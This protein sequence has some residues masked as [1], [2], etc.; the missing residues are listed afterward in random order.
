MWRWIKI[1]APRELAGKAGAGVGVG[2]GCWGGINAIIASR[3]DHQSINEVLEIRDPQ[4]RHT[5]QFEDCGD[6]T[7]SP[8]VHRPLSTN[9]DPINRQWHHG[10]ESLPGR[11]MHVN[12]PSDWEEGGNKGRQPIAGETRWEN[13]SSVLQSSSQGTCTHARAC[14][15]AHTHTVCMWPYML[16]Y[17]VWS[18]LIVRRRIEALINKRE[19]SQACFV[20]DIDRWRDGSLM[21]WSIQFHY[22]GQLFISPTEEWDFPDGSLQAIIQSGLGLVR[23]E[24]AQ[25]M[26]F[27]PFALF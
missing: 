2:V 13:Q 5:S 24:C 4:I 16:H 10:E 22:L 20:Y 23:V 6:T 9:Y 3:W 25:S 11:L 27:P 1:E 15:R 18:L 8:F 12:H 26:I 14:T 7:R 21:H 17:W 19:G